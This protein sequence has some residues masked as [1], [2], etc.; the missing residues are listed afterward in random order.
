M[1][2]RRSGRRSAPRCLR[3]RV[4]PGCRSTALRSIVPSLRAR[5][6]R[7]PRQ[8]TAAPGAARPHR[9]RAGARHRRSPGDG[10]RPGAA[11]VRAARAMDERTASLCRR[12]RAPAALQPSRPPSYQASSDDSTA[13][14]TRPAVH[15][16]SSSARA[17]PQTARSRTWVSR[18]GPASPA[19]RED[20]GQF[21]R[22]APPAGG[23][24][25]RL[26]TATRR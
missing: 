2:R 25:R 6:A 23:R 12:A 9:A 3:P 16:H 5:G 15:P 13:A 1:R 10:R 24:L 17:S 21:S 11:D 14:R 26:R 20:T 7:T 18:F 8:R 22:A 4:A 19:P